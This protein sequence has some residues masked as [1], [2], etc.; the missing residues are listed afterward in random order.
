METNIYNT[1]KKI[2]TD[3]IPCNWG[4][5]GWHNATNTFILIKNEIKIN[6]KFHYECLVKQVENNEILFCNVV[7]SGDE[8]KISDLKLEDFIKKHKENTGT[9]LTLF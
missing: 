6:E 8:I 3:W 7:Y 1:F 4:V 9:Q 2:M 5:F